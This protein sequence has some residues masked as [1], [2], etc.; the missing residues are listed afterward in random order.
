M[1]EEDRDQVKGLFVKEE[2]EGEEGSRKKV[3]RFLLQLRSGFYTIPNSRDAPL[4]ATL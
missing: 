3:T 2:G 1:N 4:T